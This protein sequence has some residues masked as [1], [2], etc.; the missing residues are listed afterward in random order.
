M[1][2]TRFLSARLLVQTAPLSM[3]TLASSAAGLTMAGSG[4]SPGVLLAWARVNAGTGVPAAAS[5]VLATCFRCAIVVAQCR[6]PVNGT[7][8]SSSVPTT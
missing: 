4:N 3:P 2:A 7:P 8:V 5:S 6:Q 1:R